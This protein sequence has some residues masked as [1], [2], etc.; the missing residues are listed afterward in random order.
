MAI[1]T[2]FLDRCENLADK[3]L[4]GKVRT[5]AKTAAAVAVVPPATANHPL[6]TPHRDDGNGPR[7]F[8]SLTHSLTH[9]HPP[10]CSFASARRIFIMMADHH[11]NN[12]NNNNN[13]RATRTLLSK[14][15][16]TI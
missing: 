5:N 1:L 16:K 2:V 11:D 14:S 4:F 15:N 10:S 3:D 7:R 12:N 6:M 8:F 13:N 9:T